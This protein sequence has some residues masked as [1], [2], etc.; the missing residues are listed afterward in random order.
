[1][2]SPSCVSKAESN[3]HFCLTSYS[4]F[5]TPALE[6][7]EGSEGVSYESRRKAWLE[8]KAQRLMVSV[9]SKAKLR[10]LKSP[11]CLWYLSVP[12][13]E[14]LIKMP[15]ILE[16]EMECISTGHPVKQIS[17]ANRNKKLGEVWRV[18][19]IKEEKK[20]EKI[21]LLRSWF[22]LSHSQSKRARVILPMLNSKID[23][24]LKKKKK[25][26]SIEEKS[27]EIT[28]YWC[29]EVNLSMKTRSS[30]IFI[31]RDTEQRQI[32]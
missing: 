29:S 2:T 27:P 7:P 12:I 31:K 20:P 3:S 13:C 23:K 19:R 18:L 30:F 21:I 15:G 6:V 4:L 8:W 10:M 28:Y 26:C 16:K 5:I 22:F 1:M 25:G 17:D 14:R 32:S 9:P 11:Y 24:R